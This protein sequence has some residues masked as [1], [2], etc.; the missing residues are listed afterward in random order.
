MLAAGR[1]DWGDGGW[2]LSRRDSA[3]PIAGAMA[4]AA[5]ASVAADPPPLPFFMH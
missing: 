5:A 2:T 1:R 3:T 4:A